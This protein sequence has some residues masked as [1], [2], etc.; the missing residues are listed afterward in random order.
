MGHEYN[1]PNKALSYR[2]KNILP[3]PREYLLLFVSRSVA[4][5]YSILYPLR[6]ILW[7]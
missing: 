2:S 7:I 6:A 1:I 4:Y 3:W 5:I